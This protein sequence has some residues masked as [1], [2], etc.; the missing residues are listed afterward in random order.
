MSPDD[1]FKAYDIRGRTDTGEIDE[2]LYFRIG[3]SLPGVLD[4][5]QISI[6]RDCRASSDGLSLALMDGAMAA[7]ANVVDLGEIPT[8]VLYYYS[9]ARDIAGGVVT[10]SHNPANYNGLKLCRPGAV[11]VGEGTGLEAIK[12]K[13]VEFSPPEVESR[14]NVIQF[15]PIPGYLDHL[16]DV[17]DPGS[18]GSLDVVVDAG[19]G[20]AGV[21][22][23]Q[24][25]ERIEAR[26]TGLYLQPDGSFPN[27]P[28]D[29]LQEEN[30]QDLV[31]EMAGSEYDLGVAFDGDADRAFFIDDRRRPVPGSTVT[32]LVARYMLEANP[33]ASI[34]HNLITSRSVPEIGREH[35]GTPIRIGVAHSFIKRVMA[36]SGAVFGGEHSGHYYFADNYRA[37]SGMLA[38]L[39]MLSVLSQSG[40]SLSALRE[41][42]ER[43]AT[44]GEV[45][46]EVDDKD[47]VMAAVEASFPDAAIDRLDGL[48]VE[49]GPFWFNLRPSN[50]EPLL[51][52]NVEATDDASLDSGLQRIR[53]IIADAS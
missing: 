49:A 2:E 39:V 27:H 22:L 32:S 9:G 52:L 20:M 53:T 40:S 31:G 37:D 29:P 14:G 13:V 25:F 19:N 46:F 47:A 26:L 34:V 35:G 51:R 24:V 7:G 23:E 17:V 15:D 12:E 42:V 38:M 28:A 44:S 45:N 33:G 11:P 8:D 50:T 16:F 41:E 10:A 1:V 36:D 3:A 4:V 30:L 21:V 5:D 6:G 48:S 18:I 43:Y